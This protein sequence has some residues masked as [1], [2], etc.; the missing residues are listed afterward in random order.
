M[1]FHDLLSAL[2]L[3]ASA[4][5]GLPI[6]AE[7]PRVERLN[8]R[9]LNA[10]GS[11]TQKHIGDDGV[12]FGAE[13]DGVIYLLE[14]WDGGDLVQQSILLHEAIHVLQDA[15]GRRYP[16]VGA[17]EREAYEVQRLWLRQRGIDLNKAL[18]LDPLWLVLV[19]NCG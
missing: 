18:G 10:L 11:A 13:K 7:A 16:C 14:S 19:G 9:D 12:V 3:F 4:H 1:A 17:Q 15:S 5:T 2:M 6:P 8:Q